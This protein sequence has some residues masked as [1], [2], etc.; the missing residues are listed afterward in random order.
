MLDFSQFTVTVELSSVAGTDVSSVVTQACEMQADAYNLPDGILGR[1]TI[2]PIVLA[3]RVKLATDRPVIAHLT[4]RDCTKLGLASRL[5]GAGVLGV[6]G[7]LALTGDAGKKNV[8]EIRAPELIKLI[9][10]L[11]VGEYQ[12][13][14]LKGASKLKIGAAVNPNV[15]GQIDYLKEKIKAGAEFIQTQP[16]FDLAV[17]EK[18][19]ADVKKAGIRIPIL[20]GI[21]PLKSVKVAEYFNEKVVG[22]TV[23]QQIVERLRQDEKAGIDICLE[24][25]GQLKDQLAGV[26]VMP[27]GQV[28]AANRI[29]EFL[30]N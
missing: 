3:N 18:F 23:S 13:K 4:C 21:M 16:V 5:L 27:L 22:I 12:E 20:L 30:K 6:D 17:A 14:A 28:E 29:Y 24:L 19:F 25:L 15:D 7:I 1:L 2:D 8:F 10:D 9:A 11:N 26:H